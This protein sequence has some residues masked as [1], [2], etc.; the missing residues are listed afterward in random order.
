MMETVQAQPPESQ[1]R[2]AFL[3]RSAA[4]GIRLQSALSNWKTVAL[5]WSATSPMRTS[6]LQMMLAT[7]YHHAISIYLSGTFDYFPYWDESGIPTPSIP[8]SQVQAHV[9]A[10]LGMVATALNETNLAGILFLFPL[11]VA[12]ARAQSLEH[13]VEIARMLGIIT[14]KGFVVAD[15]FTMDLEGLWERKAVV[16]AASK[17]PVVEG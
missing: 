12:G 10:I 9:K 5:T 1:L 11:R 17:P 16:A 3:K 4:E 2:H 6:D 14:Q 15:A 7:I 13:R 8:P